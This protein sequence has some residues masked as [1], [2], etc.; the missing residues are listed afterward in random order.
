[1]QAASPQTLITEGIKAG[2]SGKP[3]AHRGAGPH[4]KV[5]FQ[6]VLGAKATDVARTG[7]NRRSSIL[8]AFAEA[9]KKDHAAPGSHALQ[10]GEAGEKASGTAQKKRGEGPVRHP[11]VPAG[12]PEQTRPAAE[13]GQPARKGKQEKKI[14][15]GRLVDGLAAGT[16][17]MAA[18]PSS[19]VK[20]STSNRLDVELTL[21]NTADRGASVAFSA[22][23]KAPELRVHVLDVRK[24]DFHRPAE[25]TASS[26]RAPRP[27]T[28]GNDI[29]APLIAKTAGSAENLVYEPRRQS[30]PVPAQPAGALER[31]REMAGSELARA[32]GIVLR[33]G[34]GEIKLLLKP[35][36]L[37]S[38]RIRMNLVDNA[39]EGRIIVDNQAVKHVFEGGLG[40]L[41]R[42]LTAEGFQTA[43]LQVSVGGQGAND[44]RSDKEAAPRVR[45]VAAAGFEGNVPGV[46]NMSLGDL[47][48]NLFV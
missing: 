6:K 40:A 32:A 7:V 18:R 11:L 25:E 4:A 46:E 48:V 28:A 12:A 2:S 9:L 37:G 3:A 34:G 27:L 19:K 43:S 17:S 20:V 26:V 45:R 35:E 16:L 47:L 30:L 10:G 29:P 8:T 33:D 21:R 22:A 36:S 15:A 41:T 5:S 31:L 13:A 14:A 42:A 38:V 23:R 24:K 39:I 44:E 1:M